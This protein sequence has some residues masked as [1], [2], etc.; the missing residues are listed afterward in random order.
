MHLGFINRNG[1]GI[2]KNAYQKGFLDAFGEFYY[3]PL[4]ALT[5][6][7]YTGMATT[8]TDLGSTNAINLC[9]S[10]TGKNCTTFNIDQL[11][12]P[13]AIEHDG[14][15]IARDFHELSAQPAGATP[16]AVD[17]H[18]FNATIWGL[19]RAIMGAITHI[20]IPIASRV[21][22]GRFQQQQALDTTG[23]LSSAISMRVFL[24][25]P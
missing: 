17:N 23:M 16:V 22:N 20:D 24:D 15:M 18:S 1:R 5:P 2:T 3:H 9:S 13:H 10:L 4:P 19:S 11:S 25:R 8:I 14:S 6:H 7:T 12:T 21:M